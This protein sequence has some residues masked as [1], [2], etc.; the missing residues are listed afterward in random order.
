MAGI[1]VQIRQITSS[2]S[3]ANIREHTVEIDR[4]ADRGGSGK[5]VMGGEL[6]MASIGGCFMSTLL[7]A[8][9]GREAEELVRNVIVE[10]YGMIEQS[11][12]RFVAVD[13]RVSAKCTD[14]ELLEK[15][16]EIAGRGCIMVN[17]LRESLNLK[18]LVGSDVVVGA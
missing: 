11:P 18:I 7:E 17:T 9:R 15:L 8:I 10:V 16:V 12:A 3:A 2:A 5:G 4:P 14:R 13:L 6:F 1:T